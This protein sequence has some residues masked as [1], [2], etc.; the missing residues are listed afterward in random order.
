MNALRELPRRH[1]SPLDER[2]RMP[3]EAVAAKGLLSIDRFDEEGQMVEV[4][5]LNLQGIGFRSPAALEIGCYHQIL[6][7]A[8]PLR[9]SSRLRV[10]AVRP[11]DDGS[12]E[13]GAEFC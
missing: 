4:L 12:F 8:G 5:D 7:M 1:M 11:Y 6:V 9:L 3:R 13:V 2:R 10:V